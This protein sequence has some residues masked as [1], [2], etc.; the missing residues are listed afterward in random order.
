M[1]GDPAMPRPPSRGLRV[2]LRRLQ[3]VLQSVARSGATSALACHPPATGLPIRMAGLLWVANGLRRLQQP[4][5][6]LLLGRFRT[7]LRCL[8][9]IL[10]GDRVIPPCFKMS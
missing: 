10:S 1:G 7:S 2:R 5:G 8:A 6:S 9:D 4:R 3:E